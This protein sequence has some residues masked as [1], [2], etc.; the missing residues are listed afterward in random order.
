MVGEE[1]LAPKEE[2]DREGEE[3]DA[4]FFNLDAPVVICVHSTATAAADDAGTAVGA[5]AGTVFALEGL[6]SGCAGSGVASNGGTGAAKAGAG[7]LWCR[8]KGASRR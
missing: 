8:V 4:R 5:G 7:L 3:Y 6:F 2:G 1:D